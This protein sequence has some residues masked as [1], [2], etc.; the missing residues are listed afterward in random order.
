MISVG[1]LLTMIYRIIVISYLYSIYKKV[2]TIE[3]WADKYKK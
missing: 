3:N 1:A 2:S